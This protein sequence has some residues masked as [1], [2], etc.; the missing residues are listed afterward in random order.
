M[1]DKVASSSV[2]FSL[3]IP[4]F[5][6]VANDSIFASVSPLQLFRFISSHAQFIH[7]LHFIHNE[8]VLSGIF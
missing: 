1:F 3:S 7:V 5:F 4:L 8:L 6:M 2:V